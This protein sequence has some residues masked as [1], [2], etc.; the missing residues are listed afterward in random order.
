MPPKRQKKTHRFD[1]NEDIFVDPIF[2]S[3]NKGQQLFALRIWNDARRGIGLKAVQP[4]RSFSYDKGKFYV[5]QR[6]TGGG[7]NSA[8]PYAAG[9]PQHAASIDD[10]AD[11][12]D[13]MAPSANTDTN[14]I[15]SVLGKSQPSGSGVNKKQ[16]VSHSSTPTSSTT[17]STSTSSSASSSSSTSSS[18]MPQSS[19]PASK[20]GPSGANTSG[21][22]P[23]S[24]LTANPG[25]T[26][27]NAAS[28]GGFD[29]AQGPESFIDTPAY[30]YTS[31]LKHFKKVHHLK[32]FALP[33]TWLPATA[34]GVRFVATPMT[35][36]PVQ[37]MY[38]YM[39][40]REFNLIAPG[41]YVSHVNVS[42]QLINA[43]TSFPTGGTASTI[44]SAQHPK[45][46]MIGYDL[47]K[48]LRGGQNRTLSF[49][50][51]IVPTGSTA[52]NSKDDFISKQY[53]SWQLN[54]T[55]D[56]SL[57]PGT[58]YPITY[59]KRDYFCLYQ[60][61]NTLA[62]ANGFTAG[63]SM[64]HEI[65]NSCVTMFNINDKLWDEV[66]HYSYKFKNAPIGPRFRAQE[67]YTPANNLQQ[68][69]GMSD[70]YQ[71]VRNQSNLA[72]NADTSLDPTTFI[73]STYNNNILV[74]YRDN[75]IEKGAANS[76]G[77]VPNPACRQPTLH[78]GMRQIPKVDV[79]TTVT[80]SEEYVLADMYFVV[81]AEMW[82]RE[83]EYPNRF[84][85]PGT[86]NVSLENAELGTGINTAVPEALVT[87][88][89]KHT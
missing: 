80:R 52:G 6:P 16:K 51:D 44:A 7:D 35:E 45:I 11:L 47:P 42:V 20:A 58:A 73:G 65:F 81:T 39:S 62:T 86:Y 76:R 41:S 61:N 19:T 43:S 63:T 8:V 78:I 66:V 28:D 84:T 54:A 74:D 10:F 33:F 34:S 27:H 12:D 60:L 89:L 57:L 82:V 23:S 24:S 68:P 3:Y 59:N 14:P 49:S 55:W 71:A 9:F 36:I 15:F 67:I 25:A 85:Q 40:E 77:S 64:G 79:T 70:Y 29:S 69:I 13:Y 87:Y 1:P 26:G 88:G 2:N 38:F 50:N 56:T 21:V 31:G 17:Q 53:G 72:M 4:P 22:V 48:K 18:A 83:R 32:S 30:H 37:Y 46:C 5:T 75:E